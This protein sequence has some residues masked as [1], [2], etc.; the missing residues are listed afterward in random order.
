MERLFTL[1]EIE[2]MK[3]ETRNAI[4]KALV[5]ATRYE[6]KTAAQLARELNGLCSKWHIANTFSNNARYDYIAYYEGV[7]FSEERRTVIKHF[8]ELDDN[9]NIIK[10]FDKKSNSVYY[11]K[12]R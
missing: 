7:P 10:T 11:Y 4:K 8:A 6:A 5:E 3:R 2:E 9:G 12:A 1:A